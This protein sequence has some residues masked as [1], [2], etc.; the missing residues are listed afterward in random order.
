MTPV[1]PFVPLTDPTTALPL[2]NGFA[3][4][5]YISF[6]RMCSCTSALT[7][8][9]VTP[10]DPHASILINTNYLQRAVLLFIYFFYPN[11]TQ[12]NGLSMETRYLTDSYS[13]DNQPF[14]PIVQVVLLI[15]MLTFDDL[16]QVLPVIMR[17][18]GFTQRSK[19]KLSD[20]LFVN[21]TLTH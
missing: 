16:I 7:I 17:L 10:H 8:T 2:L 20:S 5:L 12:G 14:H 13:S 18:L 19:I 1:L 9:I 11:C 3:Q 4:T 6:V 21:F 15:L